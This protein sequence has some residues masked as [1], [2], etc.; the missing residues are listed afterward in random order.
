VL[1]KHAPSEAPSFSSLEGYAGAKMVIAAVRK[2]GPNP[3][4]ES[5]L[6]ALSSLGEYDLGGY[7]V[8]YDATGRRG[9]GK[10]DLTIVGA[11]GKLLK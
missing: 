6:S 4:R 8:R 2:A 9:W 5:V 11:G 10:V 1:A 3:T 7:T